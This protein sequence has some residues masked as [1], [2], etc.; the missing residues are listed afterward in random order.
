[1]PA[2][3]ATLDGGSSLDAYTKMQE[4]YNTVGTKGIN[5]TDSSGSSYFSKT[6]VMPDK[7]NDKAADVML[8]EALVDAL[9]FAPNDALK[10]KF[11]AGLK[12][13]M[14]QYATRSTSTTS[15]NGKSSKTVTQQTQGADANAF[16]KEFVGNI[17]ADMLKQNPSIEFGGAAGEVQRQLSSN[18]SDLGLF[19]SANE[20]ASYVSGSIGQKLNIKD[21]DAQFRKE[22]SVL[23]KN[24]ADRLQTT[25]LTVRDLASPYIQM[26]ADTFEMPGDTIKLTDDTIQKAINGDKLISLGDFRT[27]LR[28]DSRFQT[29]TT[30]KREA[31]DLGSS[32][33]RAFGWNK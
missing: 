24:F 29:T 32:I 1:M 23:Y 7:Y 3:K 30:A 8:T 15:G 6:Y 28:G 17:T 16:L 13:F 19:K 18:A 31:A 5:T 21:I 27:A 33:L 26:M 4:Y 14:A 11:R 9:G 12:S 22:A 25:T 20:L 10:K 2:E